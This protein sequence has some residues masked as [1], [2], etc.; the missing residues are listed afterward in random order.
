MLR[1]RNTLLTTVI[2]CTFFDNICLFRTRILFFFHSFT[3]LLLCLFG[4]V[5]AS[6]QAEREEYSV[7]AQS[8]VQPIQICSE[9]ECVQKIESIVFEPLLYKCY[10]YTTTTIHLFVLKYL[11]FELQYDF[12]LAT[13]YYISSLRLVFRAAVNSNFDVFDTVLFSLPFPHF[14]NSLH[15]YSTFAFSGQNDD[16]TFTCDAVRFSLSHTLLP[17]TESPNNSQSPVSSIPRK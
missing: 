5:A 10:V 15:F 12:I 4:F 6:E 9:C 17:N 16:S 2:V 1:L 8:A 14:H 13:C 7:S 11:E 3:P